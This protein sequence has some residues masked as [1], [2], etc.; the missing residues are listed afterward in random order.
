MMEFYW[1]AFEAWALEQPNVNLD[2]MASV[3]DSI[4]D[5]ADALG[6]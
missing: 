6:R 4:Q 2:A 1:D 3:S 5:V